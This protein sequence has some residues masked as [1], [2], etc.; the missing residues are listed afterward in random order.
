MEIQNAENEAKLLKKANTNAE[1][2][3]IEKMNHILVPIE[4]DT[5][6]NTKSYNEP[7]RELSKELI[8][9]IVSFIK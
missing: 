6:E 7:L 9:A 1:L 3:V 5:L 4:G 2:V 8:T